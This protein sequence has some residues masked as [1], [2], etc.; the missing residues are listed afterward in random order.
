MPLAVVPAE[1]GICYRQDMPPHW[2]IYALIDPRY[3]T[4]RYVG[5][6][7]NPARRLRAHCASAERTQSHKGHWLRSLLAAGL[8]PTMSIVEDGEGDGWQIAERKWIAHYRSAGARLTNATNGG[9]GALGCIPGAAVRAK[10]SS[11]HKGRKQTPESIAKTRAGLLGR[12]QSPEHLARLSAARKGKPPIAAIAAAAAA[13]RGRKQSPEH[14]AKRT[15]HRRGVQ[16]PELQKLTPDQVRDA[17]NLGESLSS[18]A[19]RL[20]VGQTLIFN[21]RHGLAYRHVI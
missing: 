12:K 21:I 10:M 20:G 1:G 4:V 14:V 16:R 7:M 6:T 3:E 19:A 18:A 13:N 11:A 9:D 15:A 5:W 17:R 8:R 2:H